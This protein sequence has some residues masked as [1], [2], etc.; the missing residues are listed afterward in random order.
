MLFH[1]LVEAQKRSLVTIWTK[2]PQET[3]RKVAEGFRS[4]LK[5]VIQAREGHIE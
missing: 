1:G 3:L 5:H 4:R 2:M